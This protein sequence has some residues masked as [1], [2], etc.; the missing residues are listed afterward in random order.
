MFSRFVRLAAAFVVAALASAATAQQWPVKPVRLVVT[1]SPGGSS[2]IVARALSVPL[3]AKLGQ[4]I[5]VDNKP[6]A[7]GT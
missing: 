2:D 7:G 5:I 4:P 3:G 6:G 1:F